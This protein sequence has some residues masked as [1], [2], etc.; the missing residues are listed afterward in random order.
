MFYAPYLEPWYQHWFFF[1]HMF[2]IIMCQSWASF[3]NVSMIMC[4]SQ[5]YFH[6]PLKKLVPELV[7]SLVAGSK[8]CF[9]II[10]D[11]GSIKLTSFDSRVHFN[12]VLWEVVP[13]DDALILVNVQL[14]YEA[15][16]VDHHAGAKPAAYTHKLQ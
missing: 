11:N 9:T 15:K 12:N 5:A 6:H 3:H 14:V 7:Y 13:Q 16:P 10:T 4:Q 1:T 8:S 2:T